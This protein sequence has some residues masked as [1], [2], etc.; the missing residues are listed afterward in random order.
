MDVDVDEETPSSEEPA[1]QSTASPSPISEDA[2]EKPTSTNFAKDDEL[3]EAASEPLAVKNSGLAA[4]A[5]KHLLK[6]HDVNL[7]DIQGTGKGGRVLKEDVQRYLATQTSAPEAEAQ[8]IDKAVNLTPNENQ[9]FRVMTDAL[10]IPH[11]GYAHSVDFTTLNSLRQKFNSEKKA[12]NSTGEEI[13]KLT[14]LSIVMKAVSLA[15]N[16][17]PRL[18][19]YLETPTDTGKPR[20]T[21]KGSHDFGIAVDTP[22]GLL[23]PVVKSVQNRSILS[24]A[25]EISRLSG[26]AKRG[27]LTP[28]DMRGATFTVSNIGSIGGS[29]VNPVI[30]PPMVAIVGVGKTEEVLALSSNELGE[31]RI[32]KRQKTMFSWSADHRVLDG[33]AV[34][35]CAELVGKL[36]EGMEDTKFD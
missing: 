29:V 21:V 7:M 25:A 13:P 15:F 36:I 33:A 19:A 32:I 8:A 24:I 27:A 20:L 23:V 16:Q 28:S 22:H 26:L 2:S 10:N 11:F 18:N 6:E 14:A 3:P 1:S 30:V 12:S 31:S 17:H 4:P 35:R 5:V 34:A 9:M